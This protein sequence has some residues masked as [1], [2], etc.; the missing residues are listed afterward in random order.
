MED[1]ETRLDPEDLPL[2]AML[3]DSTPEREIAT[4]LRREPRDIQH[5]IQRILSRLRLD[6][7]AR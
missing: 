7:P 5:A 3:L 6:V 1:A 4:V 2:L